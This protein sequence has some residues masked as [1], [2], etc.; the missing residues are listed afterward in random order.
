MGS[1]DISSITPANP[2]K[3]GISNGKSQIPDFDAFAFLGASRD[4]RVLDD[5]AGSVS[6]VQFAFTKLSRFLQITAKPRTDLRCSSP[7]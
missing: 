3:L 5:A 4:D 7:L 1:V 6:D 2:R